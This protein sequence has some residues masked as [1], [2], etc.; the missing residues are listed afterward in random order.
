MQN[1]RLKVFLT[2]AKRLSLTKAAEELFISQPAVS[3]HINAIEKEFKIKL[4]ERK[5]NKIYLT[6]AGEILLEYA[7]KIENLYNKLDF[8]ISAL[9]NIKKG[10]LNIGA[11]TTMTQYIIPPLLASFHHKF[12]NI[13]VN[14]INGNT[15]Q[16][17]NA[18]LNSQIDIGII[19]GHAKRREF[20]YIKF[21]KDE[22]VLIANS[23]HH[24]V[25]KGEINV[26]KLKEYPLLLREEGSGTLDVIKFH[27]SK[28]NL[29]LS[30]FNIEMNFGSTEGIKN[31]IRNSKALALLSVYSV[32]N[33]LKGG[34]FAIIDLKDIEMSR[35]FHF[36][37]AEGQ[38]DELSEL[39]IR[40]AFNYNF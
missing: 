31:Y 32:L 13:R 30:D 4:F 10:N 1:F 40:F 19:E 9:N 29:K 36:I 35:Y 11:S 38:N 23:T 3:K 12:K 17:E 21:L 22:I 37:K 16:I 25:K 18:L 2:V 24:L 5:G 6:H 39:F 14:L 27:L 20:K 28:L 33:E 8:E 34:E 26:E 15:E 7:K